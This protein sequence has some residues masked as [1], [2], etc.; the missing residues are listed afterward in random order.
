MK[1]AYRFGQHF[2]LVNSGQTDINVKDVNALCLLIDS[3]LQN[4]ADIILDQ[5]LLETLLARRIDAFAD[6][7]RLLTE[8]NRLVI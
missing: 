4:I 5:S 1:L 8:E 7:H 3:L 2:C 6:K